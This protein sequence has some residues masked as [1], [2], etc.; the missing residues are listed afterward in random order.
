MRSRIKLFPPKPPFI[1][2]FL[3]PNVEWTRNNFFHLSAGRGRDER[4]GGGGKGLESCWSEKKVCRLRGVF[5]E[6]FFGPWW[7]V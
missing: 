5:W 6:V 3:Y 7:L 2:S 1:S 4:R